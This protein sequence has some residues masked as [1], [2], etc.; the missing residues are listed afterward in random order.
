MKKLSK[1]NEKKICARFGMAL[2]TAM[3]MICPAFATSGSDFDTVVNP[4]IIRWSE[5]PQSR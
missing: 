2:T 5:Y 1:L 3:L 4:I